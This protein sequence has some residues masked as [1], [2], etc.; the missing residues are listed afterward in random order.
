MSESWKDKKV[1]YIGGRD[2]LR[3]ESYMWAEFQN[4]LIEGNEYE[5][6]GE[7]C[8]QGGLKKQCE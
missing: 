5:C 2:V 8:V 6:Y 3:R 7:L 4:E 1:K